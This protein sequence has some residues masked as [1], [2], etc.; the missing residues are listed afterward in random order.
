M[1]SKSTGISELTKK[2]VQA[3]HCRCFECQST[4]GL[5]YSH[6]LKKQWYSNYDDPDNIV[7]DCI[8]CHHIWDNGTFLQKSKLNS[9]DRRMDII[10][11]LFE[12]SFGET[13]IKIQQRYNT[14][15][16][17]LNDCGKDYEFIE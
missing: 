17:G 4:F 7:L 3:K 14:L 1:K 10:Y 13:K 5:S 15:V 16:Y 12:K 11:R 8:D 6:I 2:K 9:I